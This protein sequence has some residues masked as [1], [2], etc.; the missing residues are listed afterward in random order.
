MR[1][2]AVVLKLLTY[3]PSGGVVAAPTTS[4][5]EAPGHERNWDY[6]YVWLRDASRTTEGLFDLGHVRDAHAYMYWVTNAAHLS[7]PRLETMYGPHGEH[8]IK[9]GVQKYHRTLAT[10]LN[11]LIDAGLS[12]ERI[13]EPVPTPEALA[14]HPEW[15]HERRRPFCLLVR[16]GKG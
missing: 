4:L 10:L 1:R 2:S 14:R 5:P 11:G 7:G 8:W 12:L 13:V 15:I 9:E 3:A 16:A 6:R